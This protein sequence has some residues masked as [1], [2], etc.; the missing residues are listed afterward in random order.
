MLYLYNSK[1][2]MPEY[3]SSTPVI[4]RQ[5]LDFTRISGNGIEPVEMV[6][7][8]YARCG[9]DSCYRMACCMLLADRRRGHGQP[10]EN[11]SPRDALEMTEH[12]RHLDEV[13]LPSDQDV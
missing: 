12:Q 13:M 5:D 11:H 1:K 6:D 3:F 8:L 7:S 9:K 2:K 4:L 10:Q